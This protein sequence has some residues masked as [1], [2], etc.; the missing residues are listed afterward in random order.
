M[1]LLI[2]INFIA[3]DIALFCISK[4]GDVEVNPGPPLTPDSPSNTS[5]SSLGSVLDHSLS[6]L[7]LNVQSILPKI[8]I[9][10]AE[11]QMYDV[12]VFTE[13]R[14]SDSMN[15]D[16]IN[17]QIFQNPFEQMDR[18]GAVGESSM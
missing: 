18:A 5:S 4:S 13:S 14:L 16:E 1:K 12:L 7:H 3:F 6:I 10:R 2:S 9:L 17:I 8:D 15:D 11:M